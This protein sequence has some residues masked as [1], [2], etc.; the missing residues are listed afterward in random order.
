MSNSADKNALRP[1]FDHAVRLAKAGRVP[2]A[3]AVLRAL[4]RRF[5]HSPAVHGQL[6]GMYF[7]AG[8]WERAADLFRRT[9][10]LSPSSEL[11]S[12]GLIHS[13]L[14]MGDQPGAV[15]E[16]RRFLA[17]RAMP[18]FRQMLRDLG[19]DS[20]SRAPKRVTSAA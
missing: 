3:M 14:E 18:E 1:K 19:H 6:A 20:R 15:A 2:A 10:E 5:P 17:I 12:R 16:I 13:L 4:A 8:R 9:T 7:R 11:A